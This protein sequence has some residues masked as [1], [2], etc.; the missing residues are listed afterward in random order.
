MCPIQ[1]VVCSTTDCVNGA[2][3]ASLPACPVVCQV[4]DAVWDGSKCAGVFGYAWNGKSCEL[5]ECGCVGINCGGIAKD[6]ATCEQVHKTCKPY[7]P[8]AAKGCGETCNL[9][10]PADPSC[11]EPNVAAVCA[12]NGR[13]ASTSNGCPLPPGP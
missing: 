10:D 9:C 6:L 5:I 12:Q 2:C 4:E 1:G 8:C 13:C 3:V 11:V 7:D